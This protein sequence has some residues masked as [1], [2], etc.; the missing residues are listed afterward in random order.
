MIFTIFQLPAVNFFK[1]ITTKSFEVGLFF[2]I[3]S[4]AEIITILTE[5][6]FHQL[7][8]NLINSEYLLN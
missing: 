3:S 5:K 2:V 8:E 6:F 1:K 4:A 7:D